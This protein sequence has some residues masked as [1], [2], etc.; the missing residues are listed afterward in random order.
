MTSQVQ[1][2]ALSH[3]EH[4]ETELGEVT[5]REVSLYG[6]RAYRFPNCQMAMDLLADRRV[7]LEPLLDRV[8]P[9]ANWRQAFDILVAGGAVKIVLVPGVDHAESPDRV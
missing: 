5:L 3:Y 9:L 7:D 6:V 4:R 8:M 2:E 1:A